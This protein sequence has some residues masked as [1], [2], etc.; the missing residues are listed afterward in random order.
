[1]RTNTD[2]KKEVVLRSKITGQLETFESR[3]EMMK[4]LNVTAV[5]LYKFLKGDKSSILN[6][7]FEI[8]RK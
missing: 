6:R 1:M 3:N 4:S 5:T 2:K 8:E 7:Y